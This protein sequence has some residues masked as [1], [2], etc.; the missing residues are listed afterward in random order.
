ML[1]KRIYVYGIQN[2]EFKI[3]KINYPRNALNTVFG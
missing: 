1:Q 2:T 3:L